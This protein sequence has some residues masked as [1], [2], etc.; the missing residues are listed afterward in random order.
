M[1]EV[2]RVRERTDELI[3]VFKQ[4]TA[5]E[6]GVRLVGS[7]MCIGDSRSSGQEV[8]SCVRVVDGFDQWVGL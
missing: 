1:G 2:S 8:R 6:V 4:G 5:Y 3:C 7:G